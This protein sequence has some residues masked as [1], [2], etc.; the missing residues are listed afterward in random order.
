MTQWFLL[1]I[2]EKVPITFNSNNLFNII[3]KS[4]DCLFIFW[5]NFSICFTM[6]T[7]IKKEFAFLI[8]IIGCLSLQV[9]AQILCIDC[10]NQNDSISFNV[11]N[12]IINGGFEN[13]PCQGWPLNQ[14]IC[15]NASNYSSSYPGAS[16]IYEQ[17]LLFTGSSILEHKFWVIPFVN[18]NV[19]KLIKIFK[20]G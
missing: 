2:F 11:N 4:S 15:P 13:T 8:L 18:T 7:T 10:F 6:M 3:S 1:Y 19:I 16:I 9:N 12:L 20:N 5:I 14:V 17:I